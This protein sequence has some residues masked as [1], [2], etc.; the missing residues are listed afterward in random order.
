[1]LQQAIGGG[2]GQAGHARGR[3]GEPGE[4]G[5]PRVPPGTA[6][7]APWC[8]GL[9]RGPPRASRPA[10][11]AASRAASPPPRA[12][13]AK[14]LPKFPR[15]FSGPRHWPRGPGDRWGAAAR[16]GAA[17]QAAGPRLLGSPGSGF[18]PDANPSRCGRQATHSGVHTA[19]N[20]GERECGRGRERERERRKKYSQLNFALK[21]VMR[22]NTRACDNP[23]WMLA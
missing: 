4:V 1:M 17:L 18:R 12:K 2:A 21:L 23:L 5:R 7:P 9:T 14:F 10:A 8:P 6:R 3:G 16:S 15:R 13:L 20:S 11:A 19:A 22:S